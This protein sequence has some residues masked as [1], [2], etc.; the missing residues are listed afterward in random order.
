ML[1]NAQVYQGGG[2]EVSDGLSL[3][4]N[5]RIAAEKAARPALSG[6]DLADH[7]GWPK[8]LDRA[9]QGSANALEAIGYS[10]P[11]QD[12][13]VA[14]Q[15]IDRLG[16]ARPAPR[17]ANCSRQAHTAG[18]KTRSMVPSWPSSRTES[19][20]RRTIRVRSYPKI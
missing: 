12:H 15:I 7:A 11:S 18:R 17:F 9:R 20:E 10:G 3:A 19:F 6:F 1:S 13:P 5:V 16:P 8:V 14:K 2:N 4:E